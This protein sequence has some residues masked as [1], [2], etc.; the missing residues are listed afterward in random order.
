M[1]KLYLFLTVVL[2]LTAAFAFMA[3]SVNAFDWYEYR[4]EQK[5]LADAER[6]DGRVV[7]R[8]VV[9]KSYRSP[10]GPPKIRKQHRLYVEIL[11]G[12][13][14]GDVV[15]EAAAP[16]QYEALPI[17]TTVNVQVGSDRVH[18]VELGYYARTPTWVFLGIALFAAL[19]CAGLVYRIRRMPV[20]NET[21]TR[22][23]AQ[24]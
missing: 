24:R 20:G 9:R 12:S 5:Q 1:R 22:E 11:G 2:A 16:P 7:D 19:G 3:A 21:V 13:R 8:Q 10:S 14:A 4:N 6:V 18:I 15:W 23:S 17:G